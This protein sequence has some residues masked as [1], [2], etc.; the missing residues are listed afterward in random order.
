M[1][2]SLNLERCSDNNCVVMNSV[3]C[4]M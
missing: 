4:P 3:P 2:T 1:Q